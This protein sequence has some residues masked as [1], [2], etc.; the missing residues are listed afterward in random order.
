M[1]AKRHHHRS[2]KKSI[3][4]RLPSWTWWFGGFIIVIAY[5]VAFY[6]F[7]ISPYSFRW[8]AI[9]G[10]ADYPEGYEIHGID[11]SHYQ[12]NINWKDLQEATIQGYPVRFVI[13]KATE[14][15]SR[16]DNTFLSNFYNAR[17][18]GFVR[19]VYHFWSNKSTPRE[20]AQ[21]FLKN[22]KLIEGDLPPVLD[23]EPSA[24]LIKE[25]GGTEV[26]LNRIR[27][28]MKTVENHLGVKPILYVS[29]NFINKYL[30]DANDIKEEY[31]VWIARYGE[32]KPDVKLAIWQLS[33]DGH[34][35]GI[36]GEV[37]INIF[38]G[39]RDR[40]DEFLERSCLR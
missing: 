40:F 21:F 2:K 8:R 11:I 14:G 30:A 10:D 18:Y 22:V 36:H 23:V 19:G 1:A 39:Y 24:A 3:F 12:G 13:M 4:S 38:N 33:P 6:Y 25:M 28:W 15:S 16:I 32:Y 7:F 9:Y 17:E 37:D 20:Q 5:I 29:Q 35:N 26:L 31:Q 34:V 27:V